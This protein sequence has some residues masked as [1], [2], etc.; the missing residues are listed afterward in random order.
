MSK[1]LSRVMIIALI[2]YVLVGVFGYLTFATDT[3]QLTN[4][5]AGGVI[6]LATSYGDKIPMK[7]ALIFICISI[8]FTFPLNIKPT[9]DSLLDI[10]YPNTT[11]A[12]ESKTKHVALT[13]GI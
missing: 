4:A 10:L 2:L 9:K 13:F 11:E 1:V 8:I 12:E 7:I 6:L 3:N 5:D